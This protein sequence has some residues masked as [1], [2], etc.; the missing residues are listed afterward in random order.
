MM[1]LATVQSLPQFAAVSEN[2]STILDTPCKGF[3]IASINACVAL[4]TSRSF[5]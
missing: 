3:Q 2:E 4:F 5:L 1:M